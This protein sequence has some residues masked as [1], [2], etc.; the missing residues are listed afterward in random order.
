MK[1]KKENGV[2]RDEADLSLESVEVLVRAFE[3]CTLPRERW[4]HA[5]HLLVGLWYVLHHGPERACLLMSKAIRSYNAASGRTAAERAGFSARA[6]RTWIRRIAHFA[7]AHTRGLPDGTLFRR[8]LS[9]PLC[10]CQDSLAITW[11]GV[12]SADIVG[13]DATAGAEVSTGEDE[14]TGSLRAG[15]QGE[16]VTAVRAPT[17][18]GFGPQGS[19]SSSPAR[20]RTQRSAK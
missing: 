13:N 12:C 18:V 5:A 14:V 17:S 16:G 2:L 3:G 1:M 6:T 8:I 7:R 11:S 4:D 15:A 9:E 19:S 20:Y 10:R